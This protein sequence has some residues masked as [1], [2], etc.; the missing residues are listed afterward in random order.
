MNEY[1]KSKTDPIDVIRLFPDLWPD[2]VPMSTPSKSS[3]TTAAVK[4]N[5]IKLVDKDLE[6]GLLALIN[7]LTEVRYNLQKQL[8][9]S[10]SKSQSTKINQLLIT[11]D[12]TLLK[13]YLQVNYALFNY[14]HIP[15]SITNIICHLLD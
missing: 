10:N 12:T 4:T 13:C 7:Y 9:S 2:D 1:L 14:V 11:I 5:L 3:S 6:L 8:N 15:F